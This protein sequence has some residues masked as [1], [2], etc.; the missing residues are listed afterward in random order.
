VGVLGGWVRTALLLV[1]R[2]LGRVVVRWLLRA[3]D[4]MPRPP[5]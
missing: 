3:F 1:A 4:R 2:S 5:R